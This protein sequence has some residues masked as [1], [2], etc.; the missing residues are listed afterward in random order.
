MI[1]APYNG[2]GRKLI[3]AF[4]IGTTFSGISYRYVWIKVDGKII[5]L[6]MLNVLAFSILVK[7]Q[8]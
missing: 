8:K 5:M 4:D 6:L 1:F 7:C 2:P 3:L